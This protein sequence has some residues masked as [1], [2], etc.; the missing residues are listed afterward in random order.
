MQRLPICLIVFTCLGVGTWAI[1]GVKG[2]H[3][4]RYP[5]SGSYGSTNSSQNG[6]CHKRVPYSHVLALNASGSLYN[7]I[8]QAPEGGHPPDGWITILDCCDGY[9]RNVTSGLCEPQCERGCFGGRCTA[10]NVCSCPSGWRSEDGVCMP[11]CSYRCQENAYCFSPEV[12]VCKLGYDE[13]DGQCKPICPDGCKQGECVAPRVCSCRQGYVLNE[14]KEC[15]AACEGGCVHG[16]CSAPGVCTCDEGYT[17]FLGDTESCI[18][19]CPTGC[20]NGE[21]CIAPNFCSCRPGYTQDRH[22][23]KCVLSTTGS[24]QCGY[25]YTVDPDTHRCIPVTTTPTSQPVGDCRY[26]CGPHSMCVGYRCICEP[27]FTA[28]PDTGR[29]ISVTTPT[30]N[31]TQCRYG[32]G[33]NGRCVGS[34]LCVCDPGFRV[35]PDTGRCIPHVSTSADMCQYPC[36][37]GRCTGPD[38]CTC[39][40]GYTHNEYD[41]TRSRCVPVCVGGCP[42]GVCT[43]PNFCICNPGYR[44]EGVKGRQRCIPEIYS[45]IMKLLYVIFIVA[46]LQDELINKVELHTEMLSSDYSTGN[47]SKIVSFMETSEVPYLETFK[48]KT[49]G[50]FYKTRVRWNYKI[51]SRKSVRIEYECCEGF[52]R[53]LFWDASNMKIYAKCE[54]FCRPPCGNGTCTKPNLCICNYGY[55]FTYSETPEY[56]DVGCVPVCTPPCVHGKCVLPDT[57]MCDS[58]YKS[59]NDHY[60]C[61]PICNVPCP[62]GSYCYK[63]NQCLC[64][65]GYKNISN[66]HFKLTN[67]CEPICERECVHGKCTAPNICTCDNGYEPDTHD[68]FACKPTCEYGCLYG[69]CTAPN[70]CTCNEGYS[71]NTSSVC[72]PICSEACVMGTCVAPE[73]CSCFAGYGLLE[74]SKYI[75]EP[76]CEKACLNGRCTA[77]G[78][79]MCN[80]GFQLSGDETEEH[81]CKPYCETSCEPFGVCTAPNVCSCFEGYRLANK[82]QIEKINLLHFASSSVCEPI[83]EIECINGFCSA[84]WTCSCN[85]GYHPT[86][87]MSSPDVCQPIC[88][89]KCFN[90]FCTAPETC[91]C[92]SGYRRSNSW[93]ECEPICETDCING[94]C[95]APNECTC[96][97]GYQP[98]EGNRTSLCEPICNPSCKN[99]ICVQPDACSCNPGYR[100][101]M[102]SKTVCDPICHPACGTNGICEAPDLCVCKDGYRMV[103]YDR[104]NVPFRCEPIC[105][106]ECDNGTCTAP[107]FCM[108][109]DGYRN[110]EIGGCEPVCS[111]CNNGRCVAPEICECNDGFVPADPNLEFGIEDSRSSIVSENR[112]KNG[113]RCLPHCENCDNG[114]CEAPGECRCYAGFVKI[115]GTCVH[116]CQGSC[117]THGECVEERRT[118]EC[119]YGWA[120]LHCDRP[121]L[122]V[123]I[124]KNG[125]NRTDQ[126]R[127]IKEKNATIEHILKNNPACSECIGKVNNE[128]LCF[129]MF[130]ND[131]E[132]EAEIGCLMNEEC[133]ALSNISQYKNQGEM[134]KLISGIIGGI[135]LLTAITIYVIRKRRNRPLELDDVQNVQIICKHK[136]QVMGL[137]NGLIVILAVKIFLEVDVW[138]VSAIS[139]T[140]I[141]LWNQTLKSELQKRSVTTFNNSRC[142]DIIMTS[143]KIPIYIPYKETYRSSEQNM[144]EKIRDNFRVEFRTTRTC[145][146]EGYVVS[147]TDRCVPRCPQ[148]CKKGTCKEPDVCTCNKGY[149]MSSEDKQCM[150]ECTNGCINGTCIDPEVCSCNEGYWLD[151][152]GFTCR[153][154]CNAE[155]EQNHGYCSEPNVCTC[156]KGYRMSNDSKCMPECK[157]GCIN[158]TC[159]LPNI[160]TCN[161]GYRLDLDGFTCR[162]F[163]NMKCEN[164]YCS[165]PNVCK[166]NSGYRRVGNDSSSFMCEP[167]CNSDCESKKDRTCT[168]DHGYTKVNASCEPICEPNCGTGICTRP[169]LC[170]CDFGYVFDETNRMCKPYCSIPCG[171]NK[172]CLTFCMP[173]CNF[174]CINGKCTAPNVC[175]CDRNFY[176][177][178]IDNQPPLPDNSHEL[179]ICDHLPGPPCNE[180]SCGVKGTCHESGICICNDGYVRDTN[181]DCVPFCAPMCSNGTCTAPNRCECHDGFASRNESFCEPI[182]EKGC[183]NGDC[184]GPNECICHD[185]FISNLNHHLGPECIPECTRNCSERGNCVVDRIDNI[186]ITYKCTCH[187]G[188]TGQDCDQSTMCM[189]VMLDNYEDLN[190]TTIRNDSAIDIPFFED[191]PYCE[192]DKSID[193]ETLCFR[194]YEGNTSFTSCLFNKDLPCYTTSHYN[195]SINGAKIVWSFVIV[196]ISVAT[197]L[198]AAAY[199][200]YRKR[201]KEKFATGP[202]VHVFMR[203]SFSTEILLQ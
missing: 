9:V 85:I 196:T 55:I 137:F 190:S 30:T 109:F 201:Q 16:V 202:S 12:C 162:P 189:M 90:G 112:T 92:D 44:K 166:C 121:T 21:C 163:C 36:L 77:P 177:R 149:R 140:N 148:S 98:T 185:D 178:W 199:F 54:P 179:R 45:A 70:V 58:G 135:L 100:L 84:P 147:G 15:V 125:D 113:S 97:S 170:T 184:I 182:C 13:I 42:N 167:A 153:P 188:W 69:E 124:L 86:S 83:C 152:D 159:V 89:Q 176:P 105:S 155:C 14:R 104:K 110:A 50:I 5:T 6:L 103:Y 76:V 75:C 34:N 203:E 17:N 102:N 60:I 87:T 168:C 67:V 145:S 62:T 126:L 64:L 71:L 78:T 49:W 174:E 56:A 197:S 11:V 79:C 200:I 129:K 146:C 31:S 194:Q 82:M 38:Q 130:G 33:P 181:G 143:E 59:T 120:G 127:I 164:G 57:C 40:H 99:G 25:G 26:G 180:S 66:G 4:P 154:V 138:H 1:E 192:C 91:M 116:A 41:R 160:C 141:S 96:N 165:E 95:T 122:C 7:T 115:E 51:E 63:P 80:E 39:N 108:C 8:P 35:D 48:E 173:I 139:F 22:S 72:E 2:G 183:K 88:S 106:I 68:L 156:N 107:D 191:M 23:G 132:D 53:K 47:C 118:C 175:T 19:H 93:N 28:D 43:L 136:L 20:P 169:G 111:T 193:N 65:N 117:G 151:S 74:N 114:E 133:L 134:I 46:I 171:L 52:E 27:G 18:P 123:L 3:R 101:S 32:C 24:A 10:P 187:R 128:T 94:Y 81:I 195:A 29:C 157:N 144:S 150:P 172:E 198:T 61:E 73:S 37:N 158:G 186:D 142:S 131:T 161:E 119:D